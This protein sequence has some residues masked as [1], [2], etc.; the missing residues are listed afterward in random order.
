MRR[1]SESLLNTR[2]RLLLLLWRL[3]RRLWQL[4]AV[5]PHLEA[6]SRSEC[7]IVILCVILWPTCGPVAS[8]KSSRSE[9]ATGS[10]AETSSPVSRPV[11][12]RENAGDPRDTSG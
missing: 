11:S 5:R 7:K 1:P 8:E 4:V 6:R 10:L 2:L 3:G 9:P 12:G